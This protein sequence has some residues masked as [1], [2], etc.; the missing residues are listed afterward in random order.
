MSKNGLGYVMSGDIRPL[1]V[2]RGSG[3][4]GMYG[5]AWYDDLWS[6]IKSVANPIIDV[7]KKTGAIS[8]IATATGNPEIAAVAGSLGFGRRR[9]QRGGKKK[10]K[11]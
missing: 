6:G 3:K 7:A 10:A 5:G 4:K 1:Y 8:K 9:R 11:R 2:H